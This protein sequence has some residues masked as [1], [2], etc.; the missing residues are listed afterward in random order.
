LQ[1]DIGVGEG[2]HSTETADDNK[3]A[4]DK[5]ASSKQVRNM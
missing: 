5:G 3:G 4:L 2:L 1:R